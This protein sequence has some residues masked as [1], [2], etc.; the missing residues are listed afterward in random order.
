MNY[1]LIDGSL[2]DI[3]NPIKT[4]LLNRGIEDVLKYMNISTSS[5]D[6]Y[7]TLDY[8]DN[9][10]HLFDIHFCN[11]NPIG[12]VADND[13]DGICS[14]TLMYKFIKSMDKDYDVRVYVHHKNKSHG[15][16]DNDVDIDDDIKLLIVPD[17]GSNEIFEHEQL[18][19]KGIDC[20][21]A[22]HHQV[23]VYLEDSPAVILNNQSSKNYQNKNCCGASITMEFCRALENYYWDDICDNFLDLVAVA[24]VC[25]VMDISEL[26]T[27]AIITEGLS[28][29]NN[30][31]LKEIIKAQEF[32]MK[33]IINPHT[34][35]FYIG[36]LINAFI[37]LATFEER[38]LLIRAFCEDESETFEY[39]KRGEVFSTE[40]NIYEHVVRLMKS[41][42]SK[43][44]RSRDKAVASLLSKASQFE[45]DK[46]VIMDT[47]KEVDG[48][49]NGL[50]AIKISE[51]I[52]KPVLLVR[53][54]DGALMGSA[55]NFNN[56][57]VEDFR[58]LIEQ[59][60]YSIFAQGHP[61][62]CG[63]SIQADKVK[64]AIE[65]FNEQLKDVDMSKVYNVDFIID[66][67][68][69]EFGFITKIH[70][71]QGLWGHGVSEPLVAITGITLRR[72]D[73]HVQGKNLDSIAFT[74]DGVK[75]VQ[76]RMDED[77]P[78]LQFATAWNNN[79]DE[80]TID[81]VGEVSINEY[82]NIYTPQVMIKEINVI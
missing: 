18:K 51:S 24:N 25:D 74:I 39:T 70:E 63:V 53:E 52:H 56:S 41:Y 47:S 34:V 54:N 64:E 81:V 59:N 38:Q 68:D 40:E 8:I 4:V 20:I 32:S 62:A 35:G 75:Y 69:M 58:S 28:Q 12:I 67:D 15:L 73:I 65:W 21:C 48:T 9:A 76:F 79:N 14:A 80:I 61:S 10:V 3:S 50:V 13:V 82:K 5:K 42:K 22:D 66:V 16:S 1:K 57:P 36:P 27:K 43:Q 19:E 11:K 72:S 6:T 7:T 2:N 23:I 30:K 31:M 33:G 26:E 45:N 37:R 60:P 49:L 55:R 29:I 44:D 17:A 77:S 71:H 78:L 46:V